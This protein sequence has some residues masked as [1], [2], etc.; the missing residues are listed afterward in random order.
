M[1]PYTPLVRPRSYFET[2]PRPIGTAVGVFSLYLAGSIGTLYA[3]TSLLLERTWGLPADGERVVF[4]AINASNL[5]FVLRSVVLLALIAAVIH[6]LSGWDETDGTRAD[7]LCVAGWSFAPQIVALPIDFTVSWY[8]LRGRQ[9]V[10]SDDA[11]LSA[12]QTALGG[13]IETIAIPLA[14]IVAAWTVYIVLD[15]AAAAYDVGRTETLAPAVIVGAV[16]ILL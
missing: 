6:F 15:G 11:A 14:L 4:D 7:A 9:F 1:A 10:F 2:R 16:T 12:Q 8:V 13:T 3:V 5:R